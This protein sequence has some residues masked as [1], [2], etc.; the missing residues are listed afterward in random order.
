MLFDYINFPTKDEREK[1]Y[2][3]LKQLNELS[4]SVDYK[5]SN[6]LMYIDTL[7]NRLKFE[8]WLKQFNKKLGELRIAYI[9]TAHYY[10]KLTL[11]CK[12][13]IG[14]YKQNEEYLNYRYLFNFYLDV[15]YHKGFAAWD[16]IYH[17]LN[18]F[19]KMEVKINST[20]NN[21]VIIC[22]AEV[23]QDL[24]KYFNDV[25]NKNEEYKLA[26]KYRNDLTHNFPPNTTTYYET[27][28]SEGIIETSIKPSIEPDEFMKN[29]IDFINL[30]YKTITTLKYSFEKDSRKVNL[31]SE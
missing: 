29:V 21:K 15:F 8:H 28:H 20:F 10:N 24:Y 31:A 11:S 19:Y 23:N 1:I 25:F 18:I 14:E 5:D 3:N 9:I 22:L 7:E 6:E 26:K 13:H 4:L 17:L 16:F 2:T 27:K 30:F 12:V